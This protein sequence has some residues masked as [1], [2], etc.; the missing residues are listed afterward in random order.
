LIGRS[1]VRVPSPGITYSC[2]GVKR[3]V[4][5]ENSGKRSPQRKQNLK[6]GTKKHKV[7]FQKWQ[8]VQKRNKKTFAELEKWL[9]NSKKEIKKTSAYLLEC[10]VVVNSQLFQAHRKEVL[11]DRAATLKVTTMLSETLAAAWRI[12][13]E[14]LKLE[15]TR[16]PESYQDLAWNLAR[17]IYFRAFGNRQLLDPIFENLI[18][19][20]ESNAVFWEKMRLVEE[21][22]KDIEQSYDD[23]ISAASSIAHFD[24]QCPLDCKKVRKTP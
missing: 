4:T 17:R 22:A 13:H 24:Y 20:A 12:R 6:P 3:T 9:S 15:V 16:L 11:K 2:P 21:K 5:V 7:K 10:Q 14:I 1:Q 19:V 18:K 23:L 8:Q